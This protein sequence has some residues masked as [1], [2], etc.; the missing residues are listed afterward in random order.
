MLLSGHLE[1]VSD[2]L[3]FRPFLTPTGFKNATKLTPITKFHA[4]KVKIDVN[5]RK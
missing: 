5:A 2:F 3:H 1:F 4:P